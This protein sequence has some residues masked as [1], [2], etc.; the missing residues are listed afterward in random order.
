M[1]T[2]LTTDLNIGQL[3]DNIKEL[4]T[5]VVEL[6]KK[7]D[8]MEK[9]YEVETRL[10]R[11]KV[12]QLL[13]QIYGRKSE[14][15]SLLLDDGFDQC[16]LFK[17]PQEAQERNFRGAENSDDESEDEEITIAE[18]KRKKRGRKPL[19]DNLERIEMVHDISEE[20]KQCNCGCK[21]SCIGEEI[22]EQLEMNQAQFRVIR[23]IRLK[24]AC[25]NCEGVENPEG[26]RSS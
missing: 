2:T 15:F 18:H 9:N 19:P 20:E 8:E 24:Y 17:E 4:Q 3:P 12:N 21:K 22:S 16:L 25:L 6:H 14:K 7:L 10:L 26:G 1:L 11:E 5:M 13:H 23:H